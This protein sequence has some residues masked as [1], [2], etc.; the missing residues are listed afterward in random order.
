MNNFFKSIVLFTLCTVVVSCSKSGSSTE[1]LRDY[2]E[3]YTKDLSNIET[4]MQTHYMTVINNPGQ[5]NDQDV[6][7]TELIAGDTHPSIWNQ[8]Q[9]PIQTLYVEQNDITYKLYYLQLRQGSGPD[10]KSPCNVDK[11]LTSYRGE[12]IYTGVEGTENVVVSKQFEE[13]INPQSFFNLT[14][15]I[16]GW[17][18]VFPK[19]KTGTYAGNPDGTLSYFNFGAGVMFI[20]SGLAYY[21]TSTG[22]IPAY[23][24]L[25]FTFKLYEIQRNDQDAD[26]I[27][28]YQE[29]LNNDGYVRVLD[30]GVANP[31]DT[32]GDGVPDFLDNDDDGDYFTTASEIKNP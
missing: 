21:S 17:G 1:P 10:S 12:Y 24:P 20:P 32:D 11:V 15:V 4:F 14:G 30:T 13:L 29:D 19:F 2:T 16:K 25:V 9:Y 27:P 31:D 22:G 18:E 3:Q 26:G 6:T 5:T 23:S 8:T 28:S 7:F